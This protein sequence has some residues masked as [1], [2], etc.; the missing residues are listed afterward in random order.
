MRSTGCS[1]SLPRKAA[2]ERARRN[3]RLRPR[4]DHHVGPDRQ[5][6]AARRLRCARRLRRAEED[7]GRQGAAGDRHRRGQEVSAAGSRRGRLPDRLEME[8]HAAAVRGAEIPR[9]QLRRRRAGHVQG[10]RHSALQPAHPD[11]GHGDR[12]LRHGLQARLQLHSRRDLGR[13]RTLRASPGRGLCG[14]SAGRRHPRQRLL[15]PPAHQHGYGAYICG[16]E[17]ALLE[18][19]EGKKGQPRFKPPFP[20]SFGLYGKPTTI[21]NTETFAAVPW[22]ISHGR[23]GLSRARADPTTAAPRSSRC[24]ATSSARATTR[25]RW[26]R[27]SPSCWSWPAACA[28]DARSRP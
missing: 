26:A 6:L 12:R 28:A 1:P 4:R 25:S 10:P 3:P 5:Q 14:G 23:R 7:T 27:R 9:L 2:V 18:S 11:R 24:R 17:T 22:I 19:L 16:E 15:V 8:L 20:A 21:N 13:L